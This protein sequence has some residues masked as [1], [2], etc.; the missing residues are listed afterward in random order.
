MI[1]LMRQDNIV[2]QSDQRKHLEEERDYLHRTLSELKI[3][4]DR[5]FWEIDFPEVFAEGGFDLIIGNPPYV[6]YKKIV[7]PNIPVTKLTDSQIA[8]YKE[9]LHRSLEV[10][11]DFQID[12]K[13]DYYVYFI[14]QSL[15]LVNPSGHVCLITSNQWL[16]VDYGEQLQSFLASRVPIV[17]LYD[18]EVMQ[19]FKS[20]DVNTVITLLRS[21]LSD[22]GVFGQGRAPALNHRTSFVLFKKP[23]EM[24]IIPSI[25]LEI[26][27]LNSETN[28]SVQARSLIQKELLGTE[29]DDNGYLRSVGKWGGKW[30]RAPDVYFSLYDRTTTQLVHLSEIADITTGIKEGGYSNYIIPRARYELD[31][32]SYPHNSIAILKDVKKHKGIPID[33]ADSYIVKRIT[34]LLPV[35]KRKTAKILWVAA[36]GATHKCHLNVNSLPFA[37]NYLGINPK[38]SSYTA[39]LLALLNS[40]YCILLREIFGRGKGIGGGASICTASDLHQFVVPDPNHIKHDVIEKFERAGERLK[41]RDFHSIFVE[42][43]LDSGVAIK[44]QTSRPLDDR[45]ELDDLVFDLLNLTNDERDQVYL[46]VCELAKAR[47]VK[48]KSLEEE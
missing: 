7:P 23:Y 39:F 34:R 38:S 3:A 41:A 35:A 29:L 22:R 4:R 8:E 5:F 18:N 27:K 16:D 2:V 45:K 9:K 24:V 19:T 20:A 46:A 13:S 30:M 15:S 36:F 48:A 32:K 14:Y 25:L 12:S 37:G 28:S 26:R 47:S 21:P 44:E 40:T 17:S 6:A 42:C 33:E 11:F 1:H 31:R 10:L 43:G